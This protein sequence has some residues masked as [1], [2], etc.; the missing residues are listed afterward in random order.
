MGNEVVCLYDEW[1]KPIEKIESEQRLF[2]LVPRQSPTENNILLHLYADTCTEGL[3]HPF[4]AGAHYQTGPAVLHLAQMNYAN[5]YPNIFS[6]WNLPSNCSLFII[7]PIDKTYSDNKQFSVLQDTALPSFT[8]WINTNRRA[9]VNFVN[10]F[11]SDVKFY[12]YE[13]NPKYLDVM[14]ANQKREE[15]TFLGHI[16]KATDA[17]DDTFIDL[18]V[19]DGHKH[20]SI[21]RDA[22]NAWCASS[23]IPQAT[24]QCIEEYEAEMIDWAYKFWARKRES[25]NFAQPKIVPN[26]TA[27][28]FHKTVL[29]KDVYAPILAFW[30]KRKAANDFTAEGYAGPVMNQYT[31]PT[32]MAHLPQR[33]RQIL[34]EYFQ[35]ELSKWA[36]LTAADLTMT[37]LYGIRRYQRDA[38]C[39]CMLI[40]VQRMFCLQLLMLIRNWMKVKIGRCKYI[41]IRVYCMNLV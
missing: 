12:W 22:M 28:G 6:D 1:T 39:I 10:N 38:S 2:E 34:I 7:I 3:E 26:F 35:R 17:K 31:S 4:F 30:Q 23:Q 27:I 16:F 41:L 32:V 8:A 37:S 21:S 20:K 36:N 25:L 9:Q 13:K 15:H 24:P 33:E 14:H 18:Y 40:L 5:V 29:P 19:V 11:G